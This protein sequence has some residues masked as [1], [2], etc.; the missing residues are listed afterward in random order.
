M[1]VPLPVVVLVAYSLGYLVFLLW[2]GGRGRPMTAVEADSLLERVRLNAPEADS[3]VVP[4]LL[5]LLREVT[6]DDD[7]RE[8]VMVNLIKY[9][10]KAV[11]PPGFS[12]GDDPRAADARYNRAVVPLLLKRACL[13]VFLGRSA[14]RFLAPDGADEWDCVVLVR[15]RSRRD[16]LGMC[17]ELARIRADIH[18]W[19]SIE[20]TH[21]FP[22]RAGFSLVL[23]RVTTGGLFAV[24]G[25]LTSIGLG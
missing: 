20:K 18:K 5:E 6:R 25:V 1:H 14:G 23:I 9:R 2:Y 19:A 12:Y 10:R 11:Y 16:F 22:V 21:V 13:P 8:F 7:G 15:C 4:D 24:F 3:S 17:A